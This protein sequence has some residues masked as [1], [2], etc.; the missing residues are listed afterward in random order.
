MP[1]LPYTLCRE[2]RAQAEALFSSACKTLAE[3]SG[4]SRLTNGLTPDAV[5]STPR[6]QAAYRDCEL[7]RTQLRRVNAYIAKHH[8]LTDKRAQRA[9]IA[10][11][12]KANLAS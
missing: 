1:I 5:K 12:R 9:E 8:K 7:A 6:W 11:K 10:E 2:M 3:A 4:P